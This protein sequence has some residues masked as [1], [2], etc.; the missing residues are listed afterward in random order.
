VSSS[1]LAA[2]S[3][4]PAEGLT[5]TDRKRAAIVAAALPVFLQGGYLAAS[6]DEVANRAQVSKQTVYKQFT[7]K[8]ALFRHVAAATIE[9]MQAALGSVL[10]IRP[11]TD[12]LSRDLRTVARRL[13]A[14][15]TSPDLVALRRI[16]IAEADRFPDI[17]QQ[18]YD[19]G[20]RHTARRLA[21]LFA[22]LARAGRLTV[23]DPQTA[24]EHFLWLAV[25]APLNQLMFA[26]SGTGYPQQRAQTHV[27][28]AV[29]VF[30]AAYLPN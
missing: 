23:P 14:T 12:D 24:A 15:V 26:P 9:P 29:R 30:L 18:W 4:E 13:V 10:D 28:E 22:A 25:S 5:R 17:A 3:S 6:M 1:P 19:L 2:R 7:D 27:D 11:D 16:I 8:A 21:E 20:P